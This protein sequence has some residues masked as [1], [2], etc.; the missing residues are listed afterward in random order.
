MAAKIKLGTRVKDGTGKEYMALAEAVK[1]IGYHEM[2]VKRL[3]R[4]GEKLKAKKDKVGRW[5]ITVESVEEF[6]EHSKGRD[7]EV[8]DGTEY[9]D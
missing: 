1:R 3:C 4:D 8:I 9:L 5:W 7:D 2:Y 6:A